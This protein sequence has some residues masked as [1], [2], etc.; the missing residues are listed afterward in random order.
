MIMANQALQLLATILSTINDH[1]GN[2]L[3]GLIGIASAIVAYREYLLRQRPYVMPEVIFEKN[4]SDWYFHAGLFNKGEYPA[5]T[6]ISKAILKIGDEEY[7]TSFAPSFILAPGEKQKVAPLGHIKEIGRKR[8]LGHEY[9]NN[10][11]EIIVCLNSKSLKEKNFKYQTE[12]EYEVD[13]SGEN[14]VIRLIK[15]EMQ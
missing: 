13:V 9:R 11:M 15:E 2:L 12:A 7:P 10:R 8:I 5:I 4:G 14:P 3:L 6:R 1:Y